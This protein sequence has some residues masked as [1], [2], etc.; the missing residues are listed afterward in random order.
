MSTDDD[1]ERA[2]SRLKARAEV[3]RWGRELDRLLALFTHY[4]DAAE[5]EAMAGFGFKALGL[6]DKMV[7]RLK[8]LTE[9]AKSI[10]TAKVAY[11]KAEKA[12][13]EGLT[14]EQEQA[15]VQKW[16]MGME[17]V[18]RRQFIVDL[19]KSHR[20]R[21]PQTQPRA[22]GVVEMAPVPEESEDGPPDSSN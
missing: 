15:W 7:T 6:D 22:G 1:R 5:N 9:A 14:P 3:V 18:K 8:N 16:I 17:N 11:D 4:L 10:T 13:G 21:V 12:L 2:L 20:K 19:L